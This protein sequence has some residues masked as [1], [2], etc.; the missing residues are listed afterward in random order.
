MEQINIFQY[1][2]SG[3]RKRC[4]VSSRNSNPHHVA[5]ANPP[6]LFASILLS[7]ETNLKARNEKTFQKNACMIIRTSVI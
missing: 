3:D 2:Y 1:Y 5:I 4:H 7:S 6:L